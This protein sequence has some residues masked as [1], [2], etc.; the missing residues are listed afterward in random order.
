MTVPRSR[1]AK[2][3]PL[4]SAKHELLNDVQHWCAKHS[5]RPGKTDFS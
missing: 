2:K 5:S 3:A 4:F 1:I